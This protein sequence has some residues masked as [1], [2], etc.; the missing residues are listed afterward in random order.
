MPLKPS[1]NLLVR[2]SNPCGGTKSKESEAFAYE[3]MSTPQ[4]K[5]ES[6]LARLRPVPFEEVL[7]ALGFIA[8]G[9][10]LKGRIGLN[11]SDEGFLWYGTLHTALGEVPIRDFQS[12]D[13]GRYYWG[14]LWFKILRDNGIIALRLGEAALQSLGMFF[15]LLTLRGLG[16]SRRWAL[17]AAAFVLWS[18]MAVYE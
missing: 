7:I 8:V 6:M 16:V 12:Y 5:A 10:L 1:H 3:L 14:A 18:W 9:F 11:M 2:G 15:G 13:P 17:A 4:T